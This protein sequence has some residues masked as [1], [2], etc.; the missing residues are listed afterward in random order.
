[1]LL[2]PRDVD[3]GRGQQQKSDQRA[4]TKTE[5]PKASARPPTSSRAGTKQKK[6]PGIRHSVAIRFRLLFE[7]DSDLRLYFNRH[8]VFYP[9]LITPFFNRFQYRA[10]E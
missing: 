3:P 8:P 2:I 10:T 5:R 6:T 9:R 7:V 1:M 4:K